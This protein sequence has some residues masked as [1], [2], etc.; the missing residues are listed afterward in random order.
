MTQYL[1]KTLQDTR[2]NNSPILKQEAIRAAAKKSASLMDD[3]DDADDA[4]DQYT[5]KP[6][7]K[8]MTV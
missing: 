4:I 2:I 1:M 3:K 8:K 5:L 6:M 7:N